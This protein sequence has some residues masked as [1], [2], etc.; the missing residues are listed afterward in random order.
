MRA[1]CMI[2]MMHDSLR[3]DRQAG[4]LEDTIG[5]AR[6]RT[7]CRSLGHDPAKWSMR[8]LR[9][10]GTGRTLKNRHESHSLSY[11]E[12]W[13]GVTYTVPRR[14]T[15]NAPP[16]MGPLGELMGDPGASFSKYPKSNRMIRA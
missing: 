16:P 1:G 8:P 7:R 11:G 2:R 9:G 14:A 10:T 13:T 5:P 6:I 3:I 15:L 12:V 4:G